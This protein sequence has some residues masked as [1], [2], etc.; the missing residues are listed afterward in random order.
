MRKTISGRSKVWTFA[1]SLALAIF[2]SCAPGQK[3]P[4][5]PAAA[6]PESSHGDFFIRLVSVRPDMEQQFIDFVRECNVPLW[7]ELRSKGVLSNA[8]VFELFE[9]ESVL[10]EGQP[11]S[12]LLIAEL[13][14]RTS[15]DEL[16]AAT[17]DP[18]CQQQSEGSAFTIL[19]EQRLS[20]TPN[21][22][23]GSPEPSYVDAE[24]G[25]DYLIE[26]IGVEDTPA[27]LTK[28]HDLMA[29]YFGPANGLL[30]A[31]GMLH[32]FVALET[33][34]TLFEIP[35]VPV[36]NQIHISDH[37]DIGVDVDW[38]AV[39]VDLFRNEFSRELDDVWSEL[40]PIQGPRTDFR[41]R[42]VPDLCV[43]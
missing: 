14:P 43:R 16:F 23:Y 27:S 33:T 41:G 3:A 6:L 32:C 12:F 34:A 24:A 38:D 42:L 15:L 7:K 35:G 36:W 40:P 26:F 21:S 22:C 39:Y 18:T 29:N 13:G 10:H 2:T 19:S 28:Y 11:W 9:M 8:S 17:P 37:W 31:R 25:I 4:A 30:V 1:L 20:C 5:A